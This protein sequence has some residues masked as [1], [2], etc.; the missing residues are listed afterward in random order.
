M[1]QP[2]VLSGAC[3]LML[4]DR[5][6]SS[7]RC[8]RVVAGIREAAGVTEVWLC[9]EIDL[10][11]GPGIVDDLDR[12]FG[13]DNRAIRVDLAAVTFLDASGLGSFLTLQR[14]A[15]AAGCDLVFTNPRGIVARV[16]NLV[17]LE[18]ALL[19]ADPRG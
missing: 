18:S 16:I 10:A 15:R 17:G 4:S 14:R 3:R 19:G 8:V 6:V 9:G 5:C 1:N 2:T 7:R 11:S 12:L 13:R